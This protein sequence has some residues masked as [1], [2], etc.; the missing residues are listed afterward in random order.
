MNLARYLEYEK[1]TGRIVSE[2][3]SPNEP[4][5]ATGFGVFE[6]NSDEE[7]DTNLY[8]IKNGV[9]VKQ[10]ETNEERIERLK[11]RAKQREKVRMRIRSMV[12]EVIITIL[13]ND[14]KALE[15]LREEYKALKRYM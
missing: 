13:E 5:V 6:L 9:L 4:A 15:E 1:A 11:L 14:N 2:I 12:N 3:I 10:Y 7:L 8:A